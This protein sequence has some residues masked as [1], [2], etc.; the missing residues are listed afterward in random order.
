GNASSPGNAQTLSSFESVFMSFMHQQQQTNNLMMQLLQRFTTEPKA[1]KPTV[2]SPP[3]P[4]PVKSVYI[5]PSELPKFGESISS[6][7]AFRYLGTSDAKNLSDDD[8]LIV[9]AFK[10]LSFCARFTKLT[11]LL[12]EEVRLQHLYCCLVGQAQDRAVIDEASSSEELL[13]HLASWY[14][15]STDPRALEDVLR[16]KLELSS[17][18]PN[19]SLSDYISRFS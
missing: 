16:Q 10:F 13:D 7:D 2:S 5:S 1:E 15:S 19:E 3:P 18:F 8:R 11:Y 9:R 4:T 14:A 12:P 17:P 6:D